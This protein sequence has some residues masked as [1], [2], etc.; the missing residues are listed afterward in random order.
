MLFFFF[1]LTTISTDKEAMHSEQENLLA[2]P[3]FRTN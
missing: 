1:I 3:A 2:Q